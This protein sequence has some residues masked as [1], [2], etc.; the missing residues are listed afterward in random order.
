[1]VRTS[2]SRE[3]PG[4]MPGSAVSRSPGKGNDMV[5]VIVPRTATGAPGL[6]T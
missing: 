2:E 6:N 5:K 1:M 4:A 3:Q